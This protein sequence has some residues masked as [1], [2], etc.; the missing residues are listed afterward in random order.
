MFEVWQGLVAL[1]TRPRIKSGATGEFRRARSPGALYLPR[2]TGPDPVSQERSLDVWDL[3]RIGG[4]VHEA[5]D[6]VRGDG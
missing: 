3:A 6:Q 1:F 4:F 2:H 5:P